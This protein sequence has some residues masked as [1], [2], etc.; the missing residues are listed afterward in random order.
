MINR[1][2]FLQLM[3]VVFLLLASSVNANEFGLRGCTKADEKCELPGSFI[4]YN[5]IFKNTNSVKMNMLELYSSFP[6]FIEGFLSS[7]KKGEKIVVT[8]GKKML[9]GGDGGQSEI[10][11]E[12]IKWDGSDQYSKEYV[13]DVTDFRDSP[14]YETIYKHRFKGVY[15]GWK[16]KKVT[17]LKNPNCCK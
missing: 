5:N 7:D 17:E 12:I 13:V 15:M 14:D 11:V 16:L 10:L 1:N 2:I 4:M 8:K 3:L 6:V 9:F